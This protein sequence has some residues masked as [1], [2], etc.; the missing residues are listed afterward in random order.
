MART[1]EE[2]RGRC[3]IARNGARTGVCLAALTLLSCAHQIGPYEPSRPLVDIDGSELT[4]APVTEPFPERHIERALAISPPLALSAFDL[5][6]EQVAALPEAEPEWRLAEIEAEILSVRDELDNLSLGA[7]CVLRERL[8]RLTAEEKTRFRQAAFL[9]ARWG[10]ALMRTGETNDRIRGAAKLTDAYDWDPENPIVTLLLSGYCNLAG[11][12]SRSIAMLEDYLD[13]VGHHDLVALQLLRRRARSWVVLREPGELDHAFAICHRLLSRNG[14][15]ASAPAWLTLEHA[16]LLYLSGSTYAAA[17]EARKARAK[18]PDPESD[19]LTAIQAELLLGV[20]AA[21]GVD[22]VVADEH[23]RAM[24][25]LAENHPHMVRLAGWMAVP[26]DLWG[27]PLR[28]RYD[29]SGNRAGFVEQYWSASD[30]ILA[31]PDLLEN[32]IEYWRRVGEAHFT[33]SGVDIATPGPLTDPGRVILRFG[34]P[35]AWTSSGGEAWRG[36]QRWYRLGDVNRSWRF[37]YQLHTP[38]GV[39]PE[40]VLFQDH[41]SG[42]RFAAIDSLL[43]PRY[44]A[45]AFDLDLGGRAYPFNVA[46]T[47]LRE[48]DGSLRLVLCFDTFLPNYSR[49]YPLR[50]LHF[51]GD[52]CV[53]GTLYVQSGDQ[54][55]PGP[56]FRVELEYETCGADS[57]DIRRRSGATILH[58]LQPLDARLAARMELRDRR[59]DLIALGVD[60]GAVEPIRRFG[61]GRLELSD[62]VLLESLT[63]AKLEYVEERP[64][65][66]LTVYGP[67]DLRDAFAPRASHHFLPREHLSFYFEVYNLRSNENGT[68]AE[69][70]LALERLKPNGASDYTIVLGGEDQTLV[71]RDVNQWNI[72]SSIGLSELGQ[73]RYRLLIVVVDHIAG[74]QEDHILEFSI[75]LPAIL[76]ELYNWDDLA[77]PPFLEEGLPPVIR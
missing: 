76:A 66:G 36:E 60:N 16:R 42:S 49:R 10:L 11:F 58:N 33:L 31:T 18:L 37:F 67:R 14:G 70:L 38:Y 29:Q 24:L 9:N 46:M 28:L 59:G 47:R 55:V 72:V 57:L 74:R 3:A 26:W 77:T 39:R 75:V 41:G 8:G 23:F 22:Y 56:R 13:E 45:F 52:A 30:P 53:Q 20:C 40:V 63:D 64:A 54:S 48:P 73:G 61:W 62:L 19:L 51:E 43:G 27:K 65:P 32:M 68:H 17:Q 2:L 4:R 50:G 21:R 12:T 25:A 34:W 7:G 71:R 15:D 1:G 69:M 44:P 35:R 6:F 5:V